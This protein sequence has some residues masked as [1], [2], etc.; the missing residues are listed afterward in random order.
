MPWF[1][2]TMQE[3]VTR[4]YTVDANNEDEAKQ[5]I[6]N[7]EGPSKFKEVDADFDDLLKIEEII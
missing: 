5:I 1:E 4:I 3:I 7:G 2:I 6:W